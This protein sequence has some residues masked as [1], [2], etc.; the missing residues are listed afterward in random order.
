MTA[1]PRNARRT[2]IT[3]SRRW[4]AIPEATPANT[5]PSARRYSL[6]GWSRRIAAAYGAPTAGAIG[7]CGLGAGPPGDAPVVDV[8]MA[9]SFGQFDRHTG[10][11][12]ATT[13]SSR[14]FGVPEVRVESGSDPEA[15]RP[16][17][18]PRWAHDRNRVTNRRAHHSRPTGRTRGAERARRTGPARTGQCRGAGRA[19]RTNRRRCAGRDRRGW[20][21]GGGRA[22][23]TGG[24]VG[25]ACGDGARHRADGVGD[26]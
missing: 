21:V 23:R 16:P 24:G 5:R 2:A 8:V 19:H 6:G 18:G 10:T 25:A 14:R 4:W 7:G 11:A 20:R 15:D 26:A 12:C 3:G 9:Y 22:V 13:G 17:A 1:S